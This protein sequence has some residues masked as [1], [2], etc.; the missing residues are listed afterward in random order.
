MM[1]IL[2]AVVPENP[3]SQNISMHYIG[4][5]DGNKGKGKKKAK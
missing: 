3:L 1:K 2:G 5:R 4:V